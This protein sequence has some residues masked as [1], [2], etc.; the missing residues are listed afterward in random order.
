M[1]KYGRVRIKDIAKELGLSSATVSRALNPKTEYMIGKDQV[2]R[3]RECA[4]ELGYIPNLA[5]SALRTQTTNVIGVVIPDILNPVFPPMIKG[6][7]SYLFKQGYVTL[8]VF[9]NNNQDEALEE[10]R[11]LSMR[12]VDGMII[13]SAFL[14]DRSVSESLLQEI[15][16]VLACRSIHEGHLVHQ[17]LSDDQ[18]GMELAIDH[19]KQLGHQHLVHFSG[20]NTILQGLK[21]RQAFEW[22][23]QQKN[24]EYDIIDYDQDD[25]HAFSIEAGR[26]GAL[27]YLQ[28]GGK[29]TGWIA[30][31]DLMAIGA[32]KTCREM[33]IQVP[34]DV[35]ICGFNNMPMSDIVNPALTT[36]SIS[37]EEI[38]EQAARML[39][40]EIGSPQPNKQRLLIAP[41][42]V[43]RESTAEA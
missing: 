21:R 14:E 18:H 5:A 40:K 9:S 13:A 33:N 11:R 32:I 7:Q 38:G 17:V 6:I 29:A 43:V 19:M 42:L 27:S 10:V 3:V 16:L 31:N 1:S 39:V 35:S 25:E 34:K 23:C 37:Y 15:P 20:P 28:S 4:R 8:F 36:V 30:G 22:F 2:K 12:N 24:I 26:I 41:H